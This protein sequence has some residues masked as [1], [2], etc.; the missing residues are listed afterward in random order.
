LYG[1]VV[2]LRCVAVLGLGTLNL[3][4]LMFAHMV[5]EA[6][7]SFGNCGLGA[8]GVVVAKLI[9]VAAHPP[10][11]MF[12]CN[13]T[14][15]EGSGV[16]L[17]TTRVVVASLNGH[18]VVSGVLEHL[19][20]EVLGHALDRECQEVCILHAAAFGRPLPQV[21][22]RRIL[23]GHM[24]V[25][26]VGDGDMKVMDA[27]LFRSSLQLVDVCVDDFGHCNKAFVSVLPLDASANDFHEN[28]KLVLG[29]GPTRWCC[30]TAAD[31][32][33]GW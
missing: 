22:L 12:P 26:H 13:A 33:L 16:G 29:R 20:R 32:A 15:G 4:G 21:A 27:L 30:T 19:Q 9:A 3:L 14:R 17:S 18:V 24:L 2:G 11:W 7:L 10:G 1:L 6:F 25:E 23:R 28:A 31:H 5:L 8:L